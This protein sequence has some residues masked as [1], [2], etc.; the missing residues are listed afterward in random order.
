[1]SWLRARSAIWPVLPL[2]IGI[3][4][5]IQSCGGVRDVTGR[6]QKAVLHQGAVV[7]GCKNRSLSAGYGVVIGCAQLQA[8]AFGHV[9][10]SRGDQRG[11]RPIPSA[12]GS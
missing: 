8:I 6:A 11:F 1:M 3:D 7:L 4:P 2:T 12:I 5:I 10:V 9:A